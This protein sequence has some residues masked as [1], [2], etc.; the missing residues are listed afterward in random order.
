MKARRGLQ[1]V[2]LTVGLLQGCVSEPVALTP[3]FVDGPAIN[4]ARRMDIAPRDGVGLS[5]TL[6]SCT[7]EADGRL[8]V[9]TSFDSPYD[10]EVEVALGFAIGSDIID[11]LIVPVP[12]GRSTADFDSTS[13][14]TEAIDERY[15]PA[16]S[17]A[18]IDT[19]ECALMAIGDFTTGGYLLTR[20]ISKVR[21]TSQ[22]SS[23]QP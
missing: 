4:D 9:R 1:I 17:T 10:P 22:Q 13:F 23:S 7:L 11:F 18:R 6:N 21:L 8:A 16:L 19:T 14:T 5:F 2:V 20:P 15:G 12:E 3:S